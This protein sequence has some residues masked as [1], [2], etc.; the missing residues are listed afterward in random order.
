[1]RPRCR[2]IE[3][4]PGFKGEYSGMR[5]VRHMEDHRAR[6]ELPRYVGT[7][8]YRRSAYPM[9]VN[10]GDLADPASVEEVDPDNLA[11]NFG[12][13]VALRRITVEMTIR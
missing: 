13:G 3:A 6:G 8:H 10:F 12:E 5:N 7:G 1:M 11:A 9:L 2:H 4:N